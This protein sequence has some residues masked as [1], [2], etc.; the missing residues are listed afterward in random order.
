M[1]GPAGGVEQVGK[2]DQAFP[3]L[4]VA[5]QGIPPVAARVS[6]RSKLDFDPCRLVRQVKQ[7]GKLEGRG[8]FLFFDPCRLVRQVKQVGK[9]EGRGISFFSFFDPCRLVRQ[10]KQVGKLEGRGL[11]SRPLPPC[12]AGEAG[13]ELSFPTSPAAQGGRDLLPCRTRRQGSKANFDLLETLAATAPRWCESNRR[14]FGPPP[15]A[16]VPRGR[17]CPAIGISNRGRDATGSA[18]T[19]VRRSPGA[20]GR[21]VRRGRSG[22]SNPSSTRLTWRSSRSPSVKRWARL[23]RAMCSQVQTVNS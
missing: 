5:L 1:R 6:S 2:A 15:S 9:L 17:S 23:K 21:G 22:R 11:L 4:T 18:A 14:P 12:A 8:T 10:G 16:P 13:W 3:E 19:P 7:V 20:A